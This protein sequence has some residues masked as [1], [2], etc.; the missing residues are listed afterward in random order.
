M[1]DNAQPCKDVGKEEGRKEEE[2][3]G[4]KEI[5]R[6]REGQRIFLQPTEL[7]ASH[8]FWGKVVGLYYSAVFESPRSYK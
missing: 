8:E 6:E 4:G 1:V 7:P 2:R 5:R 3:E